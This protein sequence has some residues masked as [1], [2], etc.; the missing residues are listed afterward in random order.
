MF[1][2]K[3][4][5]VEHTRENYQNLQKIATAH[6]KKTEEGIVDKKSY[7]KPPQ[8]CKQN[9]TEFFSSLQQFG[10]LFWRKLSGVEDARQKYQ[11]T[12]K[13]L[14]KTNKKHD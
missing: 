2:R 7:Q 10:G 4:P 12:I 11:K 3:I 5:R 9:F 14:T 6:I 1:R 8:N 13:K